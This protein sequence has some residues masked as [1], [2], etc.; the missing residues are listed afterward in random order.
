MSTERPQTADEGCPVSLAEI[1]RAAVHYHDQTSRV[2]AEPSASQAAG[3]AIRFLVERY[4][5]Q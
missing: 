1:V 3:E 2:M 5:A 4:Q